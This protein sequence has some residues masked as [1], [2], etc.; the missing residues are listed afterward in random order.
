[1]LHH[2]FD[3]IL[4]SIEPEEIRI[5]SLKTQKEIKEF[6]LIGYNPHTNLY[7]FGEVAQNLQ[8][9]NLDS[10]TSFI[11]P[12]AHPRLPISDFI[13]AGKLLKHAMKLLYGR[14]SALPFFRIFFYTPKRFRDSWTNV[15]TD[16]LLQLCKKVTT[17][18]IY[19]MHIDEEMTL[20]KIKEFKPIS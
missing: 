14:E 12:F 7:Y 6:P 19:F 16:I 11:N 4:I 1:M 20:D 13:A 10:F 2:F 9:Q 8:R 17:T 5:K 18:S 15:E 3:T